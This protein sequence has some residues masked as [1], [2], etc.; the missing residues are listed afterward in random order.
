M[1]HPAGIDP[2]LIAHI[3]DVPMGFVRW[4]EILSRLRSSFAS[5]F[6]LLMEYGNSPNETRSLSR[7]GV[8]RGHWQAYADYYAT[9]D[10]FAA[11]MRSGRSPPG[12]IVTDQQVVAAKEFCASEYYN[13]WFRPNGIRYTAG[14]YFC[15]PE[16]RF[17]LM[18]MPRASDVGAYEDHEVR[19]LQR[20]F[21]HIVRAV[22]IQDALA[23]KSRQPDLDHFARAYGLTPAEARLVESLIATG[24][25][26][27]RGRAQPPIVF[28]PESPTA[29]RIRENRNP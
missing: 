10:P 8:D 3:Y 15:I 4:D 23:C 1:V 28:D 14:A 24:S 17:L 18:G 5:E 9:I 26:Q 2:D 25:L 21:N 6:G 19:R 13:A 11:S 22:L 16:G 27:T 7:I 20:Y 12:V 29:C